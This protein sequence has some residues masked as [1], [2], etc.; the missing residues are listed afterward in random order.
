MWRLLRWPLGAVRRS[1][2]AEQRVAHTRAE[3]RKALG[4]MRPV[5][6]TPVKVNHGEATQQARHDRRARAAA[7][8]VVQHVR[9]AVHRATQQAGAYTE[10]KDH[11]VGYAGEGVQPFW[12]G[13]LSGLSA[14]GLLSGW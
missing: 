2:H 9:G 3:S 11:V 12:Q 14:A 7:R 8:A 5:G 10:C 6:H 13:G 1:T 4:A